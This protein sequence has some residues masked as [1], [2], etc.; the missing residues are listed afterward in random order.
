MPLVLK[1]VR[2]NDEITGKFKYV[3]FST[4]V[5]APAPVADI[6]F[7]GPEMDLVR[8]QAIGMETMVKK[9]VKETEWPKQMYEGD[10]SDAS[11]WD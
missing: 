4:F 6:V 2:I 7:D 1:R 9:V 11:E 8:D 3:K 5:S 10:E